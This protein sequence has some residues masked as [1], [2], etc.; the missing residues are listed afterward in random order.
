MNLK[1]I[2][3]VTVVAACYVGHAGSAAPLI[4]AIVSIANSIAQIIQ[5]TG[6]WTVIVENQGSHHAHLW[7]ASG[8]DRIGS[9]EGVWVKPGDSLAWSFGRTPSTMFWCTLD[10]HGRRVGWDVYFRGWKDAPNPTKWA[11]RN[12]GVYDLWRNRKWRDL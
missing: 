12:D 9:H 6:K 5:A 7:C 2:F 8:S 11:I 4:G 10:Y 3:A 1:L